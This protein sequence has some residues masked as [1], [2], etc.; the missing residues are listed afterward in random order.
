MY[1]VALVGLLYDDNLGD[2][3]MVDCVERLYKKNAEK[4]SKDINFDYID[5]YGRKNQYDKLERTEKRS[6]LILPYTVAKKV[7]RKRAE[8]AYLFFERK[9][10]EIDNNQEARIEKYY[11]EKLKNMNLIVV[12]GGA[13]IKYRFSRDFQNPLSTLIKVAE[14]LNINVVFNSIGIENGYDE[15]FSTCKLIKK[16]LNSPVVKQITTR[17][18]IESLEKYVDNNSIFIG[19]TADSATWYKEL[20][21]IEEFKGEKVLGVGVISPVKF[22]QYSEDNKSKNYENLIFD[23]IDLLLK[24]NV[25]F[26][27]FTN[28]HHMDQK[29]LETIV[30]KYKLDESFVIAKPTHHSEIVVAMNSF[31]SIIASRLHACILGY[32]LNLPVVGIDWNGKLSYFGETI[33]YPERFLKP[34][35]IS[36]SK[37]YELVEEIKYKEYDEIYRN[38]YRM[39]QIKSIEKTFDFF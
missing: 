10:Y 31:H 25:K 11:Y 16:F 3:L 1:K 13:L 8:K 12:V 27:L 30:S 29:F 33:N 24:N 26:K 21:D 19:K 23:F 32:S 5:L 14:N 15:S 38:K 36:S 35:E 2:P 6:N 28:G 20:F 18:D 9:L 22:N 17:D 7:T 39:S 37:L 34:D 4:E